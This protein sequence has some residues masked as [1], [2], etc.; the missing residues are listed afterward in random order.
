M[1]AFNYVFFLLFE[2]IL[3]DLSHKVI[4]V[5]NFFQLLVDTFS[6]SVKIEDI[7]TRFLMRDHRPSV[8]PKHFFGNAGFPLLSQRY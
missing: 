5:L 8:R 1:I 2:L 4:I 7:C 3:K 6:L